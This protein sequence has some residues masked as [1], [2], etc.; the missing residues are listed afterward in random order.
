MLRQNH[1]YAYKNIISKPTEKGTA[2]CFSATAS[3]T[4]TGVLTVIGLLILRIKPN[5]PI[6]ILASIPLLFAVQQLFEGI[7]WVTLMSG[8]TAT[9][10][11]K[12]GVYGFLFFA[13]VFWPIWI[14]LVLYVLENNPQAKKILRGLLGVGS[15]VGI[16]SAL[17]I[18]LLGNHAEVISH[19]ISYAPLSGPLDE[20][21]SSYGKTLY[22][23]MLYFYLLATIGSA[24]ISTI[25]Y[26][27]FFGVLT[28][29]T[30]SIS[31]AFYI[32]TFGSVW[33][34]LTAII[35]MAA[36]FIVKKGCSQSR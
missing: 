8:S 32:E 20:Q 24:F 34:Y 1:D 11:H 12:V 29:I 6:Q 13:G 3:F 17:G 36:Y 31:Q 2:M 23:M 14:P 16:I 18:I 25:P 19:H 27:W 26:M 35:S 15:I 4:A 7:S 21:L 5:R 9:V 33:C 22:F 10:L 28:A 30:F